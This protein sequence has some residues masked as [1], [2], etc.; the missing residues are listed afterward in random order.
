MA[1]HSFSGRWTDG[2]YERNESALFASVRD[3]DLEI[4]G[5]PVFARYNGPFTPSEAPPTYP[6]PAR[7][8]RDWG[9]MAPSATTDLP[10]GPGLARD[11]GGPGGRSA[12]G[13]RGD[14]ASVESG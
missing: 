1:V 7:G 12:R 14:E 2:N 9:K 10:V 13:S 8:T 5:E 11:L 3:R 4:V 6:N